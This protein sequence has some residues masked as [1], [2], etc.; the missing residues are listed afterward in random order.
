[1]S[2]RVI[3]GCPCNDYIAPYIELLRRD[4]ARTGRAGVVNSIYRGTDARSILH[5]HGKSTQ[6]ELIDQG[7]PA[8][9]VRTAT[10]CLH[11][12]RRVWP[13]LPDG[14]RLADWQQPWDTND[15]E[16]AAWKAAAS[17]RGW[18]LDDP[19]HT[20]SERHHLTFRL[21]PHVRSAKL[22]AQILY[23]RA[24]LPRR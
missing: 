23:L 19:Y 12:D 3:S 7:Y 2:F 20:G 8:Q 9:P 21:K 18:H 11:N 22:G 16:V 13:R 14:A 1:M 24:R 15:N 4:V 5:A 17:R 6:Q 10:H